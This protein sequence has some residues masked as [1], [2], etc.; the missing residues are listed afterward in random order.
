[1]KT[2][3]VQSSQFLVILCIL[4][5]FRIARTHIDRTSAEQNHQINQKVK[6]LPAI[7]TQSLEHE[8][9]FAPTKHITDRVGVALVKVASSGQ[10]AIEQTAHGPPVSR[11]ATIESGDELETAVGA[12]ETGRVGRR[13]KS[14]Y[15]GEGTLQHAV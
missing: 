14:R 6:P 8:T 7:F 12:L 9:R 13:L 1:L 3:T 10:H 4:E 5:Y 11:S 2:E 15:S